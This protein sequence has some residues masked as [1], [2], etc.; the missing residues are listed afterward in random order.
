MRGGG[1]RGLLEKKVVILLKRLV[2]CLINY[3]FRQKV[4]EG[5][6]TVALSMTIQGLYWG[7]KERERGR[8]GGG[9]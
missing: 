9:G 7:R 1:A 5:H 4:M 2:V 6:W 3:N 8:R